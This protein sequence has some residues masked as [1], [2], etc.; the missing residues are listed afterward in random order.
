MISKLILTNDNDTLELTKHI[1]RAIQTTQGSNITGNLIVGNTHIY[2]IGVIP[3][4]GTPA[5]VKIEG[6]TIF[7]GNTASIYV[8]GYHDFEFLKWKS[9]ILNDLYKFGSRKWRNHHLE[10]CHLRQRCG[11]QIP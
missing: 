5:A 4:Q 6:N 11:F 8:G 3:N 1:F 10:Q 7:N 2:G 9:L